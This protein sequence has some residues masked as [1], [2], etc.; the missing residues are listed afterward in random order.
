MSSNWTLS[1][2]ADELGISKEDLQDILENYY[3][4]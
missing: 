2:T 3:E 1:I 4:E